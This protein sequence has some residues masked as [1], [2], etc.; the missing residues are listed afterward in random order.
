M[1]LY[2][3]GM[4]RL[5]SRQLMS[6]NQ[7]AVTD[8]ASHKDVAYKVTVAPVA[9]PSAVAMVKTQPPPV[10]SPAISFSIT[11]STSSQSTPTPGT[12]P[13]TPKT[14]RE[15]ST[16]NGTSTA[17]CVPAVEPPPKQKVVVPTLTVTQV[18]DYQFELGDIKF[19]MSSVER[20]AV[21]LV[22]TNFQ[23][24][25]MQ[26]ASGFQ[27]C[28]VC[29]YLVALTAETVATHSRSLCGINKRWVAQQETMTGVFYCCGDGV[30]IRYLG[31]NYLFPITTMSQANCFLLEWSN[32]ERKLVSLSGT[33]PS[34]V[35]VTFERA[36][37]TP[38]DH[39]LLKSAMRNEETYIG[40][41]STE[42]DLTIAIPIHQLDKVTL[43]KIFLIHSGYHFTS[44]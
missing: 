34:S 41:M 39:A 3:I 21:L 40:E 29:G 10:S 8:S 23:V 19:R 7:G 17:K 38:T 11:A 43:S 32:F 42:K 27:Y 25:L 24:V 16:S 33:I 28:S 18:D 35:S 36:K 30:A 31:F 2:L 44:T 6:V 9:A 37:L 22:M 12:A 26:I 14:P 4:S 1:K 15:S 20:R 13:E 5:I